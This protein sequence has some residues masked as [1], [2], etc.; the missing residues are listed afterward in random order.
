MAYRPDDPYN[1]GINTIGTDLGLSNI[2]Q[3]QMPMQM[4]EISKKQLNF[5]NQPI[6]QKNL[7]DPSFGLSTQQVFDKMPAYEDKPWFGSNQEPTTAKEFNEYLKSIGITDE[8]QMVKDEESDDQAYLDLGNMQ[9]IVPG[10]NP[11][12]GMTGQTAWLPEAKKLFDMYRKYKTAK[13]AYKNIKKY[14]PKVKKLI[15]KKKPTITTATGPP[16][17]TQ[18]KKHKTPGGSGYGPHTKPKTKPKSKPI[19]DRNR[20]NIPD[21]NRGNIGG[22]S[23]KGSMPT[24]TKGRNPWGRADGG[25]INFYRY[26]GF[27]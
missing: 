6:T 23:K 25:L 12:A 24:G 7:K 15:T 3:E 2:N 18:I 22:G 27:V 14:G 8:S 26:G 19:P 17:I 5:L 11:Y 16:R 1:T 20:G 13:S 9:G 10:Y 4:A 21:R